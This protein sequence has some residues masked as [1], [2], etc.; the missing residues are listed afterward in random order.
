M[1]METLIFDTLKGIVA[2]RVYPGVA[3]DGVGSAPY[4]TWQGAGGEAVNFVDGSQP[5]K[6]NARLQINVW[7]TTI[8]QAKLVAQQAET[9]LRA[10]LALSTTVL[11]GQF[12][13][14]DIETKRHGTYQF[15]SCWADIPA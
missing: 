2:N 13:R 8:I 10:Q 11:T 1:S 12:T 15:F 4:I 14:Y 3:P 6:G 9:A 7:A 5:S